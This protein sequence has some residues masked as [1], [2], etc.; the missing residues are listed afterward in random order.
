MPEQL[1]SNEYQARKTP[2]PF[3]ILS[4]ANANPSACNFA[5][6]V[7][8]LVETLLKIIPAP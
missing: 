5:T 8:D 2:E 3:I 6:R 7:H 1:N 4:P